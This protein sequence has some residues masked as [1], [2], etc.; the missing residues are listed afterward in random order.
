MDFFPV[1]QAQR[2]ER[3]APEKDVGG[4]VEIVEHVEFLV[5]EGDAEADGVVDVLD[6]DR[7]TVNFDFAGVGLVDA[8]EDFHQGGFAGAVFANERDDF[9]ARDA[10][11]HGIKATTPG[12]RLEIPRIS[13]SGAAVIAGN[14][15]CRAIFFKLGLES[16][17]RCLF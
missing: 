8:A 11:I 17:Q 15:T 1:N 12:N 4:D 3:L 7:L 6:F 13:S 5:N 9:A 2:I 10:K 16:R 14:V